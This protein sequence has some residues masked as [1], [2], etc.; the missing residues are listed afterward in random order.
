MNIR[1]NKVA[2]A[3]IGVIVLLAL[4][5]GAT[6]LVTNHINAH[7]LAVQ[8]AAATASHN[9]TEAS[10]KAQAQNKAIAAANRKVRKTRVSNHRARI[11]KRIRSTSPSELAG[12]L[13]ADRFTS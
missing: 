4:S 6:L 3:M 12:R 9:R 11:G 8:R 10:A 5:A 2:A 13:L 1:I 7:D